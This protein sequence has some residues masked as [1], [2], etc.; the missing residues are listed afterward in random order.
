[1][2]DSLKSLLT[3]ILLASALGQVSYAQDDAPKSFRINNI[4]SLGTGC[5]QGTVA[6]N[7]SEDQQA[8]TLTFSEYFAEVGPAVG[9]TVEQKTCRIKFDTEQDAG[10]EY[11]ILAVS[12]RGFASLEAGVNGQQKL[13]FG[14]LGKEAETVMDL[15]GPYDDNYINTQEVGLSKIKWSG[16]KDNKQKDF[17]INGSIVLNSSN[18]TA[19]G[20]FTVDSVDGEIRQE[21]ELLWRS[22]Q[23]QKKSFAVCRLNLE[24]SGKKGQGL[25]LSKAFGKSDSQALSK[26]RAK[27]SNKCGK[28]RK[29]ASGCNA[30]LAMCELLPL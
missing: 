10:W 9:R 25:V 29:R 12:Y 17:A 7:I 5:P 13:R 15:S 22:C 14:G 3:L 6:S 2:Q 24:S 30:N 16:C 20:L 4:Q 28:N 11:A 18:D 21:Y 23:G 27:M 19:Q 26:A 1:M 8:F